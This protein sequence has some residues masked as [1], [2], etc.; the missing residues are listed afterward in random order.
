MKTK[1]QV[2]TTSLVVITDGFKARGEGSRVSSLG[3]GLWVEGLGFM[4]DLVFR[5]RVEWPRVWCLGCGLWI[6][7]VGFMA[8]KKYAR[9]GPRLV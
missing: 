1:R 4:A 6:E 5:V 8:P 3:C 7:V 2:R 9:W